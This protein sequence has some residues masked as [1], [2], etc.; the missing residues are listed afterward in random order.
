MQDFGEFAARERDGWANEGLV[1]AYVDKFVP[2]TDSIAR[3]LVERS[4][5][6]DKSIL[7]LC[8][9]QGTLTA[10]LCDAG[11]KVTGLDFSNEMLARAALNAPEADLRQGDAGSLPFDDGAFDQ[12][13]CNFGMMHLPDQQK[14]LSEV[15]RVLRPDGRFL[16]ATWAAPDVSP[17]FG[18]VFGAIRGNADF[19]KAPAQP[20]LFV[21]AKPEGA[22]EMMKVSGL[23]VVSHEIVPAFW[24]LSEPGELFEIFLTATVAA[25]QLIKGQEPEV[26]GAIQEQITDNVRENFGDE[27]GFRVPVPVAIVEAAL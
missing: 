3:V 13:V 17:A 21:F 26:I 9:G 25:S 5:P 20:D 15:Q 1:S 12:V 23:R 2:V 7:D 6:R 16:M 19:S 18:T 8:C 10:M 11:A 27:G 4:S 24:E 22:R 14:A